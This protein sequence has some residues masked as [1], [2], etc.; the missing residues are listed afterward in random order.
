[1]GK[2]IGLCAVLILAGCNGSDSRESSNLRNAANPTQHGQTQD[3][4]RATVQDESGERKRTHEEWMALCKASSGLAASIMDARQSGVEMSKMMET[5]TTDLAK[6]LVISAFEQPRM[7]VEE[8]RANMSRDFS[9]DVYLE[10]I[11]AEN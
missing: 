5:A 10:C 9:N 11:K 3:D 2:W 8:N 4:V 6:R 1:M 7:S